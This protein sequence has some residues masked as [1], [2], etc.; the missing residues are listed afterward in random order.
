MRSRFQ[1]A[2][3]SG[4]IVRSSAIFSKSSTLVAK[5]ARSCSGRHSIRRTN[6]C[7]RRISPQERR[8]ALFVGDGHRLRHARGGVPPPAGLSCW[9]C[10]AIEAVQNRLERADQK[11]GNTDAQDGERRAARVARRVLHMSRIIFIAI[12][13][14]GEPPRSLRTSDRPLRAQQL[15]KRTFQRIKP[16]ENNI[17]A[18]VLTCSGAGGGPGETPRSSKAGVR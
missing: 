11:D 10:H 12:L 14:P 3:W 9:T 16:C 17:V 8:N 4:G 18:W 7:T 1:A 15:C 13:A 5:F 6:P 2:S